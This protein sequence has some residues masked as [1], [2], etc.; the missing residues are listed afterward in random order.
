MYFCLETRS[1]NHTMLFTLYSLIGWVDRKNAPDKLPG[2]CGVWNVP[3]KHLV[4]S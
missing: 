3:C 2:G 4:I 1:L